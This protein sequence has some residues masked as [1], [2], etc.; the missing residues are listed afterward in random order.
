M[1]YRAAQGNIKTHIQMKK[2]L[3]AISSKTY[4]GAPCYV[5]VEGFRMFYR[6][7]GTG[8]YFTCAEAYFEQLHVQSRFNAVSAGIASSTPQINAASKKL[9]V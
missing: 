2:I 4:A 8:G 3:N 5:E 9:K 1:N 6:V 7:D